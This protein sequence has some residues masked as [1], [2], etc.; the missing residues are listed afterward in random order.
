MALPSPVVEP[1]PIATAQ[2]TPSCLAS[3]RASRPVSNGTCITARSNTPTARAP[4]TPATISAEARCS[5]V[6]GTRARLQPSAS[7]S[8]ISCA[9]AP[10]PGMTRAGWAV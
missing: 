2:S 4:S 3:S 9:S 10:A 6:D 7:I 8:R 5:G 1:P